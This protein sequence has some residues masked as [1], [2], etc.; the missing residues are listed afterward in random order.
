MKEKQVAGIFL[1][2][3][4]VVL[5]LSLLLAVAIPHVG[6]MLSKSKAVSRETELQNIRTAVIEML[7]DSGAGIL[8]PV[9]P[10]NDMSEVHTRDIP[11]L[12]LSDYLQGRSGCSGEDPCTYSFTADGTVV[13]MGP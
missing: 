9:G 4:V 3:F 2:I 7:C 11:P 12:F 10:T 8:E 1:E 6:Q 5:I 13:P